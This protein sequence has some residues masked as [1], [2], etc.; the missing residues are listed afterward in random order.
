MKERLIYTIITRSN[1]PIN[2]LINLWVLRDKLLL[3]RIAS[4]ST[5]TIRQLSPAPWVDQ[6][7]QVS[8]APRVDQP[9]HPWRRGARP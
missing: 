2:L 5:I 1:T 8:P 3:R 9:H 7:R 4:Y 6:P